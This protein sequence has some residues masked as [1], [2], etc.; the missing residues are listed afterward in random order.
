VLKS[1][2]PDYVTWNCRND[3]EGDGC[4]AVDA[5]GVPGLGI[6]DRD[7]AY[8]EIEV[9]PK[10]WNSWDV[11]DMVRAWY[12]GTLNAG[13]LVETNTGIYQCFSGAENV[14]WRGSYPDSTLPPRLEIELVPVVP[15]SVP[16]CSVYDSDSDGAISMS[17]TSPAINDWYQGRLDMA[18]LMNVL[19]SWL[20]GTCHT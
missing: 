8:S 11:T 1:W 4:A 12:G 16:P 2:N 9:V 17:E 20:D 7:V 6:G 15:P 14:G 18:T 5:W 19:K 13:F 3:P 10:S